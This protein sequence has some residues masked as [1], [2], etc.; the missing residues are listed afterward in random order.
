MKQKT[1]LKSTKPI[2]TTKKQTKKSD[3]S[4]LSQNRESFFQAKAN[5]LDIRDGERLIVLL[6]LEQA[7]AFGINLHDKVTLKRQNGESIVADVAISDTVPAGEIGIYLDILDKVKLT[8]NEVISVAL[9][10]SST[11]SYDAIRKK[12]RGEKISY[13]E[14]YSI[15][16]D[17]SENKLDDTMMTYYVASSFFYPTTDEEMYLTAKAMAECGVT[18]K[19]PKGEII[20][21]KHCIGGVPGNETT[22]VLIPL[23]AS[24][25]IKIP[26]NFSKSITSPAATGECVNVLMDINFDKKGIEKLVKEEDCCLVWGGSLDLA[27]A[28][29]K[30]IKVQY[31][32]SMQS[33]AKVVSSIM[34]K[35]YAM[36]IT[37]SL[38][39]IP[40]GPTAKVTT[41][42]EAKDWKK[43]FEYVGKKLWMKMSVVITKADEVIGNGVGAVLQV[44]E[45]LRIL[46]QHPERAKDLEDKVLHL[47]SKIIQDVGL[48]KGKKALELAKSQ[49]TSGKAWQKMQSIIKAQHGDPK[50]TSETLKLWTHTY[51][52]LA[53]KDG[54]MKVI[55]LHDVNAICRKLGCPVINEAGMYLYKKLGDKVKKWEKIATL[56]ALD[57]TKLDLG[58]ERFKER[59][60]FEY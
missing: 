17:I 25:G 59:S 11:A 22:M 42:E 58:I 44:R 10:E 50:I 48:A 60:P 16:K 24:L 31:P 55:N 39:D 56:Y 4:S 46:Q 37:H 18:F 28:D 13:E 1:T 34:A 52:I 33:R 29:D 40:V 6:N 47:A 57:D 5:I 14:M 32:L 7:T 49:L 51:D 21:D 45:V 2:K 27:P 23:I 38:I 8:S 19:Y 30:L 53:T 26:K 36:G 9:A 3:F 54:Q 20:A 35:K 15:I 41:M 43:K 12:M